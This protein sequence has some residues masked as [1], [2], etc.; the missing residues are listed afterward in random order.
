MHK[1]FI[2]LIVLA[3]EINLLMA[4]CPEDELVLQC[5]EDVTNFIQNYPNCTGL[6]DRVETLEGFDSLTEI[7]GDISIPVGG[8]IKD[9]T[10][11]ETLKKLGGI[12]CIYC[13]IESLKGLE[14]VEEIFNSLS[15]GPGSFVNDFS[16]LNNLKSIGGSIELLGGSMESESF[17]NLESIGGSIEISHE[18]RTRSLNGFNN[19]KSISGIE[20][21][22]IHNLISITGFNNLKS[23]SWLGIS[24]NDSLQFITGFEIL[25]SVNS[26][27]ISNNNRLTDISGLSG[28]D[29]ISENLRI[30]SNE[31]LNQCSIESVCNHIRNDGQNLIQ[32]NTEGC[33]FANEV[34]ESCM[35][36]KPSAG[37]F[38]CD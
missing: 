2:T 18:F 6:D 23:C 24:D 20:I 37:F 17:T 5:Q 1:Y 31:L 29:H 9:F 14:N 10:G 21:N 16:A 11:L 3:F 13:D 4:Q 12:T 28:V 8:R 33:N 15:F 34:L 35:P 26:I 27:S 22:S 7:G 32:N 36:D 25:D 38:N 19:L 30:V